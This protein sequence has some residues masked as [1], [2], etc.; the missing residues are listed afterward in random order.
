MLIE[1]EECALASI[2]KV[3]IF[4][5]FPV[6]DEWRVRNFMKLEGSHLTEQIALFFHVSLSTSFLFLPF[7]FSLWA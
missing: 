3:K 1:L 7:K 2:E 4:L 5:E 6:S